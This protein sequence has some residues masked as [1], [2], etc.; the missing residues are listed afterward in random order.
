MALQEKEKLIAFNLK[1]LQKRDAAIDAI[2]DMSSHVVLYQFDEAKQSWERKNIEGALFVVRRSAEPR[3][4]FV[5]MNKL[6]NDNV[7]ENVG[8]EFQIELSDQFLLYRNDA[9]EINGIWF[10]SPEERA[11]IAELLNSLAAGADAA[12]SAPAAPAA[13]GGSVAQFFA[14]AGGASSSPPPAASSSTPT[15]RAASCV[16]RSQSGTLR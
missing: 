12:A 13:D 15:A 6:S 1:T 7:V 5:V 10:Y 11:A 14:M 4:Q 3:H 8:P 2:L 16:A 9:Q